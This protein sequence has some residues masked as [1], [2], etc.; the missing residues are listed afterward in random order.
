M[1]KYKGNPL[2]L[3]P[4][5]VFIFLF[6]GTAVITKDFYKMPLIV[7]F[8]IAALVGLLMNK[9]YSFSHKVDIFTKGAGEPNIILMCL[10]FILAGAFSSVAKAMGGV[11]S[12]V[13]LGLSLL[14]HNLLVVGIF[15]IGCFISVSM[16]TSMGT[17][18]ALAPIG[19]GIAEKTGI[20]VALVI[21]AVVGGAM[22]GDNLS[23][24]SDTTI[25][26]VRTQGCEMKDKFKMNFLIVLPPAI[27]TIILLAMMTGSGQA[28]L[29][30][31]YPFDL[32]RVL[33]YLAVLVTA[34]LGLNVMAV[35]I[36]GTIFAGLVGLIKGAFDVYG[37]LNAIE[38]GIIGMENL[39]MMAIIVGGIVEIIKLNG[40]I[41][42]ILDFVSSKIKTKKG[43]ELGIGALVSLVDIC[44]A[45][46]TI[47]I[48]ITGP[49][50]KNIAQKYE[51][52]PRRTASLLDLFSCCF[53]G[54]I[55]YGGQLLVAAG[56]AAISPFQIIKYL[57]YPILVGLFG[58]LAI[59]FDFP[60]VKNPQRK[61][62]ESI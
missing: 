50:A 52:D 28:V 3:L 15:I 22:F 18:V 14:P 38:N 48:I 9:D 44:T 12:T 1:N 58:L 19:V 60:K 59:Y 47:A 20:P 31:E 39:A 53:Q 33:P 2:A 6:I 37:L 24:I 56:L 49:L 23:M 57:H 54:I 45:N 55:P 21:G 7:A 46:N 43:A 13:N 41:D 30:G 35:L 29:D 25:T 27:I 16:G 62:S 8:L 34:L 26:A 10:I 36:G 5:L 4:I 17:I 61:I 11:D 40:G 42:F 51:I 32:I